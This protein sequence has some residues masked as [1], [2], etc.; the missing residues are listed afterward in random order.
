MSVLVS[1]TMIVKNEAATLD[2]CLVSVRDI[3]DEV[4]VVDTGSTDNTK[5]IAQ[6]HGARVFDLPWPDSFAVARNE[7]IRHANGQWILWL[8]ADEHFDD[9]NRDRLRRLLGGLGEENAAYIMKCVCDFGQI[10]ASLTHTA[11]VRLFRNHPAIRWDYR[12]HEQILPAIKR[13]GHAI[14]FHDATI[15]DIGYTNPAQVNQKLERNLRLLQ[16]DLAER[17]NDPFTLFNLGWTYA[18][19]DRITDAIPLLHRSLQH[20]HHAN[21]ITPKLYSLL[22]LCHLRLG[23]IEQAWAACQAGH[24]LCPYDADLIFLKRQMCHQRGPMAAAGARW[25]QLLDVRPLTVAAPTDGFF[26]SID[27]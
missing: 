14:R 5:A 23:Q 19:L 6:Q 13:A 9:A 21:T 20:S 10:G 26:T 11:H 15:T 24:S 17:P 25:S 8:D 16:L 27:A 7:S 12:V 2:H 3:V 1:L 22:A 4:I 18:D